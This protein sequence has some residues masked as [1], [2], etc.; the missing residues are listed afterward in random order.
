MVTW[1]FFGT[2]PYVDEFTILFKYFEKYHNRILREVQW[3]PWNYP[4]DHLNPSDATAFQTGLAQGFQPIST[5]LDQSVVQN[6]PGSEYDSERGGWIIKEEVIYNL[7]LEDALRYNRFRK[8][9][10]VHQITGT[11]TT[12]EGVVIPPIETIY[13]ETEVSYLTEEYSLPL[14][15]PLPIGFRGNFI[16][17]QPVEDDDYEEFYDYLYSG[18]ET[19]RDNVVTFSR[20]ECHSSCHSNC[21]G[22]RGRR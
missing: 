10:V 1:T 5:V 14:S 22:S 7:I 11:G 15:F 12:Q 18:Y 6:D 2:E 4:S 17:N 19:I 13:D 20:V 8:V 16:L 9:R 3:Y 21:H